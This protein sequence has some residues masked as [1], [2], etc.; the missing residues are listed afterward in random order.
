M[1]KEPTT[2][3]FRK[4]LANL[5]KSKGLTQQQLG[6]KID[7]SKRV[8]VYYEGETKYLLFP[9]LPSQNWSYF[10]KIKAKY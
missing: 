3:N 6:D 7:V 8:I 10:T 2:I 5:R 1:K 4:R 9:K